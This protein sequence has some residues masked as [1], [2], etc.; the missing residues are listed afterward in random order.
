MIRPILLPGIAALVL[1]G[2]TTASAAGTYQQTKHV[3]AYGITLSVG[4]PEMSHMMGSGM[5]GETMVGGK[6]AACFLK[7]SL[8]P[9][10]GTACNH[11]VEVHITKKGTV[12][13]HA[14]VSITLTNARTHAVTHVPIMLMYGK[15]VRDF[16]YGNNVHVPSGTYQAT[17]NADRV[18][19]TFSVKL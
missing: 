2:A 6:N 9:S 14:T 5:M 4:K 16:H 3:G 18:K 8:G 12:D 10:R 17:V 1:A 13:I 15:D 11:H 19:T 7:G